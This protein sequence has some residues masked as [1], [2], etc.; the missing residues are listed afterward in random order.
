MSRDVETTDYF[1]DPSLLADPYDFYDNVRACPVRREPH[2]G[3]MMVSGYDE[4]AALCRDDREN[5]S[6]CNVISGPFPGL[7]VETE[8]DD[9]SELI[10]RYRDLLPAHEYVASFD[11]PKHTEHRALLSR[12]LTPKR[13][14]ENEQYLWRLADRIIDGFIEDG[15]C[16]FVSAFAGPFTTFAIA[17][18]LGVPEEDHRRFHRGP[19]LV[20]ALEGTT[21]NHIAVPEDWFVEYVEDRRR[22]P[23]N[24]V[25]TGLSQ[26]TFPDGSL[27]EPIDVA[28]IAVFLFAAG[29]GTTVD[30]LAC[31]IRTL[32]ENADLQDQLR[33]DKSLVPSF[34]EEMLRIESP[35]K[36]NF[37]LAKRT[38]TLANVPIQAG[39]TMMLMVAAANRDPRH[40]SEPDKLQLNRPNVAD[41]LAFGRGIHACPG[42]SLARAE[43]SI[44]LT[45]VLDRMGDIRVDETEHGPADARR[46]EWASSFLLRRLQHMHVTFTPIA[47]D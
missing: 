47:G 31:A 19:E 44:S 7:P 38:T 12:L 35:V 29:Q 4:F 46:Y 33:G 20:G 42:S 41:H 37:R 16:D 13:L 2:H 30:H 17:D 27:P 21:G 11:P 43:A 25:L 1:T 9:I 8:G 34:I 28:R 22:N 5:Y 24:D 18:L 14:K 15:K 36:M 32:A 39:T 3:V 23:R 10:D 26:T 40:F 45:R 6:A